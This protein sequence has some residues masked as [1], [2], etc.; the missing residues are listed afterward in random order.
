MWRVIATDSTGLIGRAV[1]ALLTIFGIG[2][3]IGVTMAGRFCD[4]YWSRLITWTGPFLAVGWTL[5]AFTLAN[6]VALRVLALTQGA[7]SF[8]LGSA[9]IARIV[10]TAN[11]APDHGGFLRH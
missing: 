1:P 10:A 7:L 2:A 8:A 5:L 11:T 4:K 3:F 6:P 9:L